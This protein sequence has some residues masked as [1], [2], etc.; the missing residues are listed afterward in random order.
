MSVDVE[1]LELDVL[2]SNDWGRFRPKV[3]AVEILGLVKTGGVLH[4]PAYHFL[5]GIG[6]ALKAITQ[7]TF[8]FVDTRLA[9]FSQ[10][11]SCRLG[12]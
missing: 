11:P 6:Y 1:G 9:K 8:F 7:S 5:Q 12:I 3:M 10:Y 4:S 2:Q